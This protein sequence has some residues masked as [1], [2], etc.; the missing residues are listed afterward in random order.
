M[1]VI[2]SG[3]LNTNACRAC[4]ILFAQ[5]NNHF[6]KNCVDILY[7]TMDSYKQFAIK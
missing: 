4:R 6:L 3:E 7:Y 2:D 1:Q 5:E